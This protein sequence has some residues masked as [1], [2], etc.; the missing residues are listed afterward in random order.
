MRY[1]TA[2]SLVGKYSAWVVP[3]T[4][5]TV[6]AITIA[7]RETE[8]RSRLGRPFVLAVVVFANIRREFVFISILLVSPL[9]L[10]FW[11]LGFLPGG[12]SL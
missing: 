2:K 10:D 11:L 7:Q 1:L 8:A 12:K 5:S 4:D 6:Q 9:L 3:A